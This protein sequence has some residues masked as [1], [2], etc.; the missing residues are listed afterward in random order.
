MHNCSMQRWAISGAFGTAVGVFLYKGREVLVHFGTFVWRKL[1]FL[2]GFEAI[3]LF[4][5]GGFM[6][7][8]LPKE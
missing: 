4:K 5:A 7:R 6:F 2:V 1:V 3:I 8:T